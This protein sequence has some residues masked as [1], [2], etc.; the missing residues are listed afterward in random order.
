ME[1]SNEIHRDIGKHDA[2][3][4]ALERDMKYMRQE[5]QEMRAE[6]AAALAS[7]NTTLSEAKGGWKT[8]M[9]VGG[10]GASIG[11]FAT[12]ALSAWVSF[13]GGR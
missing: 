1:H 6:F 13:L 10:A 4:E 8:L 2:Q 11:I 3:I 7:I 9:W 12:K 5:V